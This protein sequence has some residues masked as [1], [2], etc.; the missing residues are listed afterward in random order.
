MRQRHLNNTSSGFLQSNDIAPPSLDE[1]RLRLYWLSLLGLPIIHQHNSLHP[2]KPRHLFKVR[3]KSTVKRINKPLHKLQKVN[4]EWKGSKCDPVLACCPAIQRWRHHRQLS[5]VTG[6]PMP[7]R[8]KRRRNAKSSLPAIVSHLTFHT[9]KQKRGLRTSER[10]PVAAAAEKDE[11]P[12]WIF[13]PSL[14]T[15]IPSIGDLVGDVNGTGQ[16]WRTRAD[17]STKLLGFATLT[18]CQLWC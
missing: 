9:V 7:A 16:R 15:L 14:S 18:A 4:A 6:R 5:Q 12:S 10:G 3:Q 11:R 1:P 8:S 17:T 2:Y 13:A